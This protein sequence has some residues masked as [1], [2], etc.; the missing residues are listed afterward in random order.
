MLKLK[1]S[2]Y[3][4]NISKKSLSKEQEE[5]INIMEKNKIILHK[6]KKTNF[7]KKNIYILILSM[8]FLFSIYGI[9]ELF[10]NIIDSYIFK[11]FFIYGLFFFNILYFLINSKKIIFFLIKKIT[12]KSNVPLQIIEDINKNINISNKN[13]KSIIENTK[14]SIRYEQLYK[15]FNIDIK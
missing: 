10:F 9:N 11:I 13:K 12:S 15:I 4:N 7:N 14:F 3:I 5:F 2:K 8:I 1:E 6:I